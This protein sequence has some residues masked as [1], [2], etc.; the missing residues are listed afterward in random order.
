[1]ESNESRHLDD[2]MRLP[3]NQGTA[4]DR[5]ALNSPL[6]QFNLFY[7]INGLI[8]GKRRWNQRLRFVSSLPVVS[9]KRVAA[10]ACRLVARVPGLCIRYYGVEPRDAA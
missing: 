2:R 1:M 3:V 10:A 7:Y 6:V 4:R 9:A 5:V 8:S